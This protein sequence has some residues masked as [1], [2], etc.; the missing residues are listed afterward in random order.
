MLR[1]EDRGFASISRLQYRSWHG[2]VHQA[3]I[4]RLNP[5][6]STQSPIGLHQ[7]SPQLQDHIPPPRHAHHES[8]RRRRALARA[9]STPPAEARNARMAGGNLMLNSQTPIMLRSKMQ[10]MTALSTAEA[11]YYS[12]SSGRCQLGVTCNTSASSSSTWA[13]PRRLRHPCTP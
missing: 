13:S 11:E 12:A 10:K 1:F 6:G 2:F 9:R 3:A 8:V 5:L 7:Q 4:S